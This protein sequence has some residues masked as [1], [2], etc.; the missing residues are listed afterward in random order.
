MSAS[1]TSRSE[2]HLPTHIFVLVHLV[3]TALTFQLS[4]DFSRVLHNDLIWAEVAV[5]AHTVSAVGCLHDFHA[6]AVL[7]ALV[8]ASSK[9]CK[10][11][12]LTVLGS[13]VAVVLVAFVEHDAVLAILGATIPRRANALGV[14]EMRNFAPVILR[15]ANEAV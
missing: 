8:A 13:N 9:L 1:P 14:T 7:A 4:D 10:C 5:A 2:L 11:S 6:N 3:H 12:I 15:V